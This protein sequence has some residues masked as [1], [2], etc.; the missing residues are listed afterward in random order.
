[1]TNNV[2]VRRQ[3]IERLAAVFF[4]HYIIRC[5]ITMARLHKALYVKYKI[6]KLQKKMLTRSEKSSIIIVE[7]EEFEYSRKGCAN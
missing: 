4:Y 5:T 6:T 1:M 7:V 2:I 3:L